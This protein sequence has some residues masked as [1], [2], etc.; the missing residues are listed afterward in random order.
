MG[1][2]DS[3]CHHRRSQKQFYIGLRGSFGDHHVNPRTLRSVHLG[4]MVSLEGIVTRCKLHAR[5][6]GQSFA[7]TVFVCKGSLVRPKIIKS[8][9]YA[10]KTSTFYSRDY[11][12]ATMLGNLPPSSTA[13]PTQDPDGNPL[14]TEF[15][16]SI[17]RDHQMISIQEMPERAPPGQLPRS[18]DVVMDDDL[19]DRCKP[20]DRIQLVGMFRSLGN[21]VGQSSTST[22]K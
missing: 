16:Y 4:K 8:V 17:F 15:G 11:R 7:D 22:F 18:I 9:H 21:R 13:Y 3:S 20:G 5:A 19:V 1:E 14:T 6:Q 10:E 12:D 2:H